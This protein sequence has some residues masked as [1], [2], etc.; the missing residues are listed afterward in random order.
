MKILFVCSGGLS[1]QIAVDALKKEATAKRIDIE[2][3]AVGS[4]EYEQIVNDGFDAVMV[5]PQIR[6]RFDG[7]K[8]LADEANVPCAL[9]EPMAY[10]PLGAPKLL[11]QLLNLLE[12]NK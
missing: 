11:K 12:E 5:A 8:E 2:V 4:T 9:I 6:H 10:S 1:S 3:K 7:I